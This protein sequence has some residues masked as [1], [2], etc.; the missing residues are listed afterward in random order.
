MIETKHMIKVVPKPSDIGAAPT[1]IIEPIKEGEP[2]DRHRIITAIVVLQYTPVSDMF[3]ILQ[4]FKSRDAMMI[5]FPSN[6]FLIIK[7]T[8][9]NLQ[10]LLSIVKRMDV[11]GAAPILTIRK[12]KYADV[13]EITG[14]LDEIISTRGVIRAPATSVPGPPTPPTPSRKTSSTRVRTRSPSR[15]AEATSIK[16]IPEIR[17]NSLIILAT[18]RETEE[19]LGL[20]DK[21]DRAATEEERPVHVYQCQ[22]QVAEDL[23]KIMGDFVSKTISTAKKAPSG[24]PRSRGGGTEKAFFIADESTNKILIYAP[25]QD[26]ANYLALLKELD[27]PQKQVLIEVWIVGVS[28]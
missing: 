19:V 28:S 18:E 26:Y 2:S 3:N 13:T 22:Y 25:P 17:T 1:P 23:A 6:N 7:E 15:T 27:Q 12:L 4:P 20:I 16:I 8:E 10:Y 14:I 11:K 9:S 24:P 21:L 5:P